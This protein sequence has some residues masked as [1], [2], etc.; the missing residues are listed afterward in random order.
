MCIKS[1]YVCH[2][3]KMFGCNLP[4][5]LCQPKLMLA[6]TKCEKCSLAWPLSYG[7]QPEEQ[8]RLITNIYHVYDAVVRQ[9]Q[10]E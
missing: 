2:H 9:R 3:Q 10:H 6:E 8:G 4:P 1:I 5:K 7:R